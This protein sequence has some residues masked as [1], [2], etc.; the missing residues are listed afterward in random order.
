MKRSVFALAA[1]LV[2]AMP[3]MAQ[4]ITRVAV[5]DMQKIYL[6][7]EK[8]SYAVRAFEEEKAAVQAEIKRLGDEIRALQS[9]RLELQASKDAAAVKAVDDLLLKKA[10]FLSDY[11]R[12]KQAELDEKAR[13]L[14]SSDSFAQ[15]LYRAIQAV[16]EL[17]G[18]S[19]VISARGGDMVISPVIWYSPMIDITDK[20]IQSLLGS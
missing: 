14:A 20:V 4:Q 7:Y 18:Y 15:A 16:S 13:S 1:L 2:A 12:I 9:K 5:I 10:Q 3:A 8:D 11:I 17:E 6:T 19:L